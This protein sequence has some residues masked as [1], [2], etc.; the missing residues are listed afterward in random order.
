MEAAGE[1]RGNGT[2]RWKEREACWEEFR[3]M[4]EGERAKVKVNE[5]GETDRRGKT[6]ARQGIVQGNGKG[7]RGRERYVGRN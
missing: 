6:G 4:R 5:K 2:I 7:R 3:K 1:L